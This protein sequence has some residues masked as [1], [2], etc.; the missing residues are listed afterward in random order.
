MFLDFKKA[1]DSVSHLFLKRLLLHMGLPETYVEWIQI[2]YSGAKT[3]VRHK[4]WLMS[5]FDMDRGV[6]Q[7]CL[8]SCY[9][10]NLVG[11][12]L[13]YSLRQQGLFAWWSKPGDP[14]SL[15]ADDMALFFC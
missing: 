2:I 11:Q 5:C 13:V 8:L 15:Y 7:G 10:F 12:V 1:F 6:C 9:L 4:N 14:C 3:V